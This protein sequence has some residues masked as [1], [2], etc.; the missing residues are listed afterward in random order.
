MTEHVEY[1]DSPTLGHM[2]I[3]E[4]RQTVH[5]LRLI[6][7]EMP[8]L[9]AYRKPFVPPTNATPV[10]VRSIDYAGEQHPATTKRVI[11]VPVDKLPLKDDS[12]IHKIKL[13]AGPRWT[14]NP[15]ADA[16]VAQSEEWGNGYIKISCENFPKPAMNLKWAS[17][18]LD[19]LITQANQ[20]Q[21]MFEHLPVDM[22]HIYAKV[23]KAKKGDHLRDRA[24]HRP[25][26]RDFPK[27]WLP[28]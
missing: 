19:R 28:Q 21:P 13:L 25:T 3:Q 18:V 7:L 6:E 12:A 26:I 22:R 27:S 15:P 2:V 24:L 1:D 16:G 10:V 5:F 11:V 20:P 23:R 8:K 4:E 14:P 9:V 17:D